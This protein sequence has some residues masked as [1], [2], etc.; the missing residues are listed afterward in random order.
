[1]GVVGA[2]APV[3]I[4]PPRVGSS[5]TEGPRALGHAPG[6]ANAQALAE[7]DGPAARWREFV[8]AASDRIRERPLASLGVGLGLG[9][10]IGGALSFRAGRIALAA[11]ARHVAREILKQVL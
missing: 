10:L 11:A 2:F 8:R 3:E 4:E 5:K 7:F 1:M 6:T 9:F